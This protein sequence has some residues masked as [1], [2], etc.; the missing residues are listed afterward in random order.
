MFLALSF[1]VFLPMILFAPSKFATAFTLGSVLVIT[2]FAMLRGPRTIF[3][4]LVSRDKAI[5]SFTYVASIGVA[6]DGWLAVVA[7]S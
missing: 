2:A 6:A 4:Q 3:N 7:L 5:F 1:F